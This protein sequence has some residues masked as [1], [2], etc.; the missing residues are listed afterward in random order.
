MVKPDPEAG[1]SPQQPPA[2]PP[3]AAPAAPPAAAAEGE[4][5]GSGA[6]AAPT[7]PAAPG[8]AASP[9]ALDRQTLVA[10]LQFLRRSNLRESEEI[11]RR[12]ARLLGDD[13]GA[14]ALSPT[15]TGL[16]GTAGGDADS[17]GEN[18]LLSRV[19]AAATVAIGGSAAAVA[20]SSPGVAAVAAVPPGKGG[21][22]RGRC[23]G[24][25]GRPL[26]AG[27]LGTGGTLCLLQPRGLSVMLGH[28]GR[29]QVVPPMGQPSLGGEV[30]A[31]PGLWEGGGAECVIPPYNSGRDCVL[32]G[33]PSLEQG[34]KDGVSFVFGGSTVKERSASPC[35]CVPCR[36]TV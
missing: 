16:L 13:V 1:T 4:V 18:A 35:L 29:C 23:L 20:S 12:E 5:A 6:E 32:L 9:S 26:P 30:R 14:A 11:L 15:G 19:T 28:K 17:A 21:L 34:I 27:P 7:K 36:L 24:R 3:A 2:A 25:G 8:P 33:V 22:L 31:Y 10:V